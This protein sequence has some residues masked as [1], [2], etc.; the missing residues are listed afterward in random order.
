MLRQ[1]VKQGLPK[2]PVSPK[3]VLQVL[4]RLVPS[5]QN[6]FLNYDLFRVGRM[7]IFNYN[8]LKVSKMT[9]FNSNL[10]KGTKMTIFNYNLFKVSKMNFFNYDLFKVNDS[11][12][13]WSSP[14]NFL[15]A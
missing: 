6:G 13:K 9:I 10:F 14:G 4:L 11:S 3:A 1:P 8:L 7:T 12:V 2:H 15:K 5:Q